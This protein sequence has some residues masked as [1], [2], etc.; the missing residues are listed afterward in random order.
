MR[1]YGSSGAVHAGH[2]SSCARCRR[3]RLVYFDRGLLVRHFEIYATTAG[4]DASLV[5][6]LVENE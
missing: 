5:T 4:F 2:G 3:G 1:P 6:K